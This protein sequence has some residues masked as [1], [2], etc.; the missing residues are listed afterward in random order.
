[1]NARQLTYSLLLLG[2]LLRSYHYLREPALWHDEAALTLNVLAKDYSQMF[3]SLIHHEAAPPLFLVAEKGMV[4]LFGESLQVMRFL[5]FLAS[6]LALCLFVGVARRSLLAEAVPWAVGL[7]AVSDRLLWHASEAKPYSIDVFLSVLTIDLWQR[8][9]HLTTT[10]QC[11][12][13]LPLLPLFI[14]MSFPACF[15]AG[16]VL[17]TL[18]T[19]VGNSR[20]PK[21]WGGYLALALAVGVSFVLLAVGPA[22]AQRDGAMEGCWLNQFPNW[23][24]PASVPFWSLFSTLEVIR[25]N[26]MPVGHLLAGFVLVGGMWFW[27]RG[28]R[29]L[30]ILILTPVLA[31]FLAACLHKYPFGGSRIIAFLAPAVILLL[32]AGILPTFDY[33]RSWPRWLSAGTVLLLLAPAGLSLYRTVAPWPRA[34]TASAAELVLE[35]FQP[36]DRVSI[37]HW[38]YEFYLR[39]CSPENLVPHELSWKSGEHIWIVLAGGKPECDTIEAALKP[40]GERI[41]RWEFE[42]ACVLEYRA[43]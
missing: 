9:R 3:G 42:N 1:M 24:N 22:K 18:L 10:S 39:N 21:A 5:P 13:W 38:E 26:V 19:V 20:S 41:N 34:D 11:L 8:T 37:N 25:Y 14:W 27:R 29:S 6:C 31:V 33:L 7:F 36:G 17:M 30:V 32:S 23:D 4:D 15:V 16:G 43:H 2:I 28:E 35:H 12:I 40:F